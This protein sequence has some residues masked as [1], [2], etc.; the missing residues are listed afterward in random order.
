LARVD[1]LSTFKNYGTVAS[2]LRIRLGRRERKVE[3]DVA[4]EPEL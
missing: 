2:N 1:R 4:H 3:I